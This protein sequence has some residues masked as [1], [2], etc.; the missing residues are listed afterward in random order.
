MPVRDA[1]RKQ[2]PLDLHDNMTLAEAVRTA[3]GVL[4]TAGIESAPRDAR[5]LVAAASQRPALD[6]IAHPDAGLGTG[7][8]DRLAV[9]IE[10]RIEREPVSRIIG[11]REFYGRAFKITPA[12]LDPRPDT[13][14]LVDAALELCAEQ[15]SLRQP[16]RILDIGTGS[17]C[18]IVTLLSELPVAQGVATDISQAALAVAA[19]NA[20]RHGVADRLRLRQADALE[21]IDDRYDLIVCNPPYI[22]SDDIPGLAREVR[23]YDPITALDGGSEGL[24]IFQRIAPRLQAV[25]GRSDNRGWALFEVGAGQI[26]SV[27][28]LLA[29]SGFASFRTWVD[30]GGHTRCVAIQ[31]LG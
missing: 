15:G 13:E 19:A 17:G 20:D 1:T 9:M 27:Q 26:A 31:S 28:R 12:T 6:L 18:L 3:T 7:T 24:Q 5:A 4:Q 21:G 11:E 14:T 16:I 23:C 22:R 30:L 29:A 8:A 25:L 2:K 10:R